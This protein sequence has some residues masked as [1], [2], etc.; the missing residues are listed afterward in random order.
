MRSDVD[1]VVAAMGFIEG[2][3]Q[4]QMRN[5]WDNFNTQNVVP[6]WK[7]FLA[8]MNSLFRGLQPEEAARAKLENICEKYDKNFLKFCEE[9]PV[10]AIDSIF[11]DNDLIHRINKAM[12]PTTRQ[13]VASCRATAA[14]KVPT[15]WQEYLQF[16]LGIYKSTRNKAPS[17]T[18][19]AAS[20]TTDKK[21]P[22][23]EKKALT[24]EQEKWIEQGKCADCGQHD[25]VFRQKCTAKTPK[26]RGPYI[27]PKQKRNINAVDE[28][29][30]DDTDNKP[31]TRGEEV[32]AV[33]TLDPARL[34]KFHEWENAQA[35]ANTVKPE[36]FF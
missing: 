8:R 1:K 32:A 22:I 13:T 17:T 3:A 23:R 33:T 2:K 35:T 9:F 29:E 20:S 5:Y 27:F 36:D 21:K 24:S 30:D 10:P 19:N 12:D 11:S 14:D 18:I 4:E 16:A 7:D 26:Y 6:T 15:K 31:A 34:A 28:E 25:F